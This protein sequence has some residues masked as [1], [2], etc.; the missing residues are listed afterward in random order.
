[1]QKL[2]PHVDQFIAVSPSIRKR[3]KTYFKSEPLLIPNGVD[4]ARFNHEVDGSSIRRRL[5]LDGKYVIVSIGRLSR[6]KGL[7]YLIRATALLKKEIPTLIVLICGRGEEETNLKKMVADLDLAE[8]VLFVGYIQPDELPK[9]YAACDVFV[10]PSVFETFALT[11]LEALSTG[12]PIVCARVGGAQQLA[13]Q[14]ASDSYA[15][16]V[17]PCDP[18]DLAKGVLWFYKNPEFAIAEIRTNVAKILKRYSWKT[19]ATKINAL[20]QAERKQ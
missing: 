19:V 20:Y 7:E 9:Y 14:F 3:W 8:T 10:L 1:V 16:L 13:A 4:T 2:V 17:K 18:R 6:Q 12:K 11:L 5:N 15:I